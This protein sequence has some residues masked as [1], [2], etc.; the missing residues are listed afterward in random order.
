MHSFFKTDSCNIVTIKFHYLKK[1]KKALINMV[2]QIIMLSP[3]LT[4]FGMFCL[5]CIVF[6]VLGSPTEGYGCS[7][8][9]LSTIYYSWYIAYGKLKTKWY[10]LPSEVV[11]VKWPTLS[12]SDSQSLLKTQKSSGSSISSAFCNCF[13][14]LPSL[15][16]DTG[17]LLGGLPH[18]LDL[19]FLYWH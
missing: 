15:S 9:W 1:K 14:N 7:S 16:N 4:Y 6:H 5:F 12:R 8:H 18:P 2:K 10:V 19:N 11:F 13:P 17:R 3:L